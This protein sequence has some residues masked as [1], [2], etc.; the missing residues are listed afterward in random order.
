MREM[1]AYASG[2]GRRRS[3]G[4]HNS[5][6]SRLMDTEIVIE[7]ATEDGHLSEIQKLAYAIWREHY[8]GIISSEQIEYM[9]REGYSFE[10]LQREFTQDGIRYDRALVEGALVG[11]SAYGPHSDADALMIHKL[12]VEAAQRSKGCARKLVEAASE[13]A[14]TNSLNRVIL[15]VNK[16]NRVAIAAYER[17]GFANQGSIVSDIGSGFSMDD[18]LMELDV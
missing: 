15:R 3:L 10:A 6:R 7:P 13:H 11:F 17:M 8:P 16:H 4:A 14:L 9:L 1:L 2:R 5:D 12:Y 18:Y